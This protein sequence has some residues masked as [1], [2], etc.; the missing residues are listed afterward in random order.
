MEPPR[1]PSLFANPY[2]RL[3]F[4]GSSVP[5]GLALTTLALLCLTRPSL[6]AIRLQS[7]P[8]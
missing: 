8:A 7:A 5:A 1:S 4:G 2:F 6:R 3:L